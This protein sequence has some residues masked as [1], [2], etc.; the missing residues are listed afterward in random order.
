[1]SGA[2]HA[3]DGGALGLRL[4]RAI[5]LYCLKRG[6]SGLG[7]TATLDA[8]ARPGAHERN[9]ARCRALSDAGQF[10]MRMGRHDEGAATT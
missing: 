7:C 9:F 5:R 10:A 6:Q 8:L 2:T 3:Q 1:M 4:V